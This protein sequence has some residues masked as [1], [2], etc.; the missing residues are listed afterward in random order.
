V[1]I[2]AEIF[3]AALKSHQQGDL[4]AAEAG[5]RRTIEA[6]PTH[7]AAH[8]NLGVLLGRFGRTPEAIACFQMALRVDPGSAD[9]WYNLGNLHRRLHRYAE[10]AGSYQ[11]AIRFDP[12]HVVATHNLGLTHLSLDRAEDAVRSFERVVQLQPT[13][14]EAWLCLGDTLSRLG[15][16][17]DALAAFQRAVQLKPNEPRAHHNLGLCLHRLGRTETALNTLRY[18]L[19]LRA[20]YA[21]AHN[22]LGVVLDSL[23]RAD[24]AA[25]HYRRAVELRGDFP[26]ALNNLANVEAEQAN[27]D[28]AIAARRMALGLVPGAAPFHSG[29]LLNLHYVDSTPASL[30]AEHRHWATAHAAEHYPPYPPTIEDPDPH[31]VLRVGYVSADFRQHSLARLIE[32]LLR[33]HDKYR[34]HISAFS[35]HPKVDDVTRRIAASVDTFHTVDRLRDAELAGLIRDE[36][37]DILVDL[38]GHVGGNRLL[39]FARRP[40]PVQVSYPSWPDTTGLTAIDYR[41]TDEIS[42]PSDTDD[43]LYSES[44]WRLDAPAWGW[45]IPAEAGPVAPSPVST[46][47]FVVFGCFNNAAKLTPAKIA[48]WCEILKAVPGSE[49][50]LLAGRGGFGTARLREFFLRGGIDGNR[51]ICLPRQNATRYFELYSLIDIALDPFPWAGAI[52]TCDSLWMGVPVLTQSGSTFA[53]RQGEMILRQ[54]GLDDFVT[55]SPEEYVERAIALSRQPDGLSALRGELRSRMERSTLVNGPLL[56]LRIEKAYREMWHRAIEAE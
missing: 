45:E 22:S 18:A 50:A 13:Y 53:S 31:R 10:A 48:Q 11:S 35:N 40:A 36:R 24:E 26:D 21:E 51:V 2:T 14:F 43:S 56:A 19:S 34:F 46:N 44:L 12:G 25:T 6:E 15:R 16:I 55:R 9:L 49:L 28:V 32:P 3:T 39:T 33:S 5:Y 47:G 41:L 37:I 8:G 30:A 29:L 4:A 1:S 20:D 38:S 23:D 27:H 7:A 54:V 52:T 42:D 17:D